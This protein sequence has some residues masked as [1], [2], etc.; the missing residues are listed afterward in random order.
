MGKFSR[1]KGSRA[2]RSIVHLAQEHGFGARR[3]P[4]S[5]A[6]WIKG[7][8]EWPFLGVDRKLEVKCRAKGFKQVYDWLGDNYAL[9][10]KADRMPPLLVIPLKEAAR[11]AA[12]AERLKQYEILN[13]SRKT[14]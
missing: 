4:L 8:I 10:V 7:D 5:G 12:I 11:I 2:E 13:D 1:D 3:V 9:I 6:S 14:T